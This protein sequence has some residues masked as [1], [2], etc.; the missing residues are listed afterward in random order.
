M[1]QP[2]KKD[3]HI[4]VVGDGNVGKTSFLKSQSAYLGVVT[5]PSTDQ[6]DQADRPD[7]T[8]QRNSPSNHPNFL[9]SFPTNIGPLSCTCSELSRLEEKDG[10]MEEIKSSQGAIIMFDLTCLKS[11]E[12]VT[13]YYKQITKYNN[14]IPIVICGTKADKNP[15]S[16]LPEKI[17]FP[18]GTFINHYDTSS[19][20]MKNMEK[21]FVDLLRQITG[22][23]NIQFVNFK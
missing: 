11:Y 4:L 8:D 23:D 9:L 20:L 6:A 5:L 7:P 1:I 19:L 18:G 17:C 2:E 10:D 15:K 13:K 14:N 3:I 12:N 16:V 22:N 21:P